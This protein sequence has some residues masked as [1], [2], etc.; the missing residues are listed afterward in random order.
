MVLAHHHC[1]SPGTFFT[2]ISS[3]DRAGCPRARTQQAAAAPRNM[4]ASRNIRHATAD[5]VY[6]HACMVSCGAAHGFAY[7]IHISKIVLVWDEDEHCAF[8]RA[9]R[10]WFV[11]GTSFQKGQVARQYSLDLQNHQYHNHQ[12]RPDSRLCEGWCEWPSWIW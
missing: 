4:H 7:T 10:R 2:F 1:D 11:F 8:E 6:D 9:P 3:P 12:I 5:M